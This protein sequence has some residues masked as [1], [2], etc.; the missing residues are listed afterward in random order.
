MFLGL[1]TLVIL[2]KM[3]P[4]ITKSDGYFYTSHMRVWMEKSKARPLK[5]N[6][7]AL[8]RLGRSEKI[9][10]RMTWWTQKLKDEKEL[11]RLRVVGAG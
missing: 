6:K 9:S 7:E 11:V 5:L 4:L 2:G 1:I 3:H 8:S 10:L